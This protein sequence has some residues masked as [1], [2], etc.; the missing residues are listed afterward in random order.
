MTLTVNGQV[1]LNDQSEDLGPKYVENIS[2]CSLKKTS[3]DQ[4]KLRLLSVYFSIFE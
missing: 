3:D 1:R 2:S 4:R